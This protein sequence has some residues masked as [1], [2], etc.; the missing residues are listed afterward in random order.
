MVPYAAGPELYKSEEIKQSTSKQGREN[1][2][3]CLCS[4]LPALSFLPLKFTSKHFNLEL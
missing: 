4:W 2:A 1:A 3:I